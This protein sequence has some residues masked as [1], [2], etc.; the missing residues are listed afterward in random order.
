M[1]LEKEQTEFVESTQERRI[2]GPVV[3]ELQGPVA[4]F[5]GGFVG[6]GEGQ[7]IGG[8]DP[9]LSDQIGQTGGEG[10]GL[11]AAGTREDQ[12]RAVDVGGRF[13]LRFVQLLKHRSV[14]FL[15]II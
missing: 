5:G 3:E 12:Q 2:G 14:Y 9:Y 15:L 13:P 6:E 1:E 4:H 11:A 7:G 8:I 10:F